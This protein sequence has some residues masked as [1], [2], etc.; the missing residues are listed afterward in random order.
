MQE[1]SAKL[2]EITALS[3]KLKEYDETVAAL[4]KGKIK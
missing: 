4:K 3:E 1:K 2:N